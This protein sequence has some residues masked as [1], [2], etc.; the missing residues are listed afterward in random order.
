MSAPGVT[1]PAR[2]VRLIAARELTTRLHTRSFLVG[3]AMIIAVIAGF[4]VLQATVLDDAERN[5]IGLT[6]QAT[7]LAEPITEA[8]SAL[9]AEIDISILAP[10]D[11]DAMVRGGQL[12]AVVSGN[13][14]ELTVL[15]EQDLDPRIGVALQSISH[16]EVLRAKLAEAGVADPAAVLAEADATAVAVTTLEPADPERAQRIGI[17]VVVAVLLFMSISSY[18]TLVAQGVVEEK[19]S[20]VVEILLA[21]VQPW[22]LL[23]GKVLGLG[24]VG[25]TQIVIIATAGMVTAMA[26]GVLTLSGVAV[27]TLAWGLLWYVIGFF[28][29]ATV[30]AAAGSLVSRQE[31]AQTVLTPVTLT[32][33]IGFVFGFNL[34]IRDPDGTAS[35]VLSLVPLFSP[36]LMPGRIASGGV[37]GWEIALAIVLTLAAAASCSWLG[38]RIYRN[39]V[40]RTGGRMKLADAFRG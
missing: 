19:A 8:A 15:V 33:T 21:T 34:L 5:A 35:T 31:D 24:L 16:R 26:T 39:A 23:V 37:A 36:I 14:A 20:R 2:A 18:G 13:A 4:F 10:D 7:N 17:G 6:G 38:G 12:D 29:Y 9:G 27:G 40:L 1:H 30:F 25:L 22:Q 11:A 32:L 3:T 28:L